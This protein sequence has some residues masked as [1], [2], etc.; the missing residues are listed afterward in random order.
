M[1]RKVIDVGLSNNDGTGDSIRDSFKK[2]N[3]N[4][5]ELYASLGLGERLRFINLDDAP[6]SY[7]N[8]QG[9][10]L[11][12]NQT[13]DGLEFRRIQGTAQLAID[14]DDTAGT[15][16]L[17]PLNQDIINDTMMSHTEL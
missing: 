1:V 8:Q 5:Q 7:L 4:F 3:D 11:V 15:I 2:V 10:L 12:V 17:R 14:V 6:G 9:K 16:T 13:Q